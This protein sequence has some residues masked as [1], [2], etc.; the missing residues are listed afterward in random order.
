[1]DITVIATQV[2]AVV[3]A[4]FGLIKAVQGLVGIFKRKA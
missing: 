2:S 1:M 3:V 4:I